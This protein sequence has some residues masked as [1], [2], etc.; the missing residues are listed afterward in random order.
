[1]RVET[2]YSKS[3]KVLRVSLLWFLDKKGSIKQKKYCAMFIEC[4]DE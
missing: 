4:A 3:S 1:M 2:E